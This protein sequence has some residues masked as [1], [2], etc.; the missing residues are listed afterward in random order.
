[1]RAWMI[2][3][4]VWAAACAMA[5]GRLGETAA[6]CD[7]RYGEPTSTERMQGGAD[8]RV[9]EMDSLVIW[10]WMVEGR[11]AMMTYWAQAPFADAEVLRMLE[12]NAQGERWASGGPQW[13]RS[14]GGRAMLTGHDRML[15]IA[16]REWMARPEAAE[17][18]GE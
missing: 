10:V 14:D 5:W 15:T 7:A 18:W 6:Q 1:M 9:Y 16:G 13:E 12:E 8:A 4:C 11:A 2:A 17:E 3:G